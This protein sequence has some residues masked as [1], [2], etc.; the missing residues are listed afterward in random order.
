MSEYTSQEINE[1]LESLNISFTGS[2]NEEKRKA[3]EKLELL[4]KQSFT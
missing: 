4:S 3:A 2:N 1:T